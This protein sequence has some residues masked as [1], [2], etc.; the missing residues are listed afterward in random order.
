MARRR[1]FVSARLYPGHGGFDPRE[2]I[3]VA[4]WSDAG[5]L[6]AAQSDP[7]V[8]AI[9]AEVNKLVVFRRRVLCDAPIQELAALSQI[10]RNPGIRPRIKRA[11]R[12]ARSLAIHL[13]GLGAAAL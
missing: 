12:G 10:P 6:A 5:L 11:T 8:R 3:Q 13:A 1:G 7:E 9:G 4:Q 2:Y